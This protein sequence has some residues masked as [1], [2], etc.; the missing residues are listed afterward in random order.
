MLVLVCAP[1]KFITGQT[2]PVVLPS[3][4]WGVQTSTPLTPSNIEMKA[5]ILASL[6]AAAS[7]TT[8]SRVWL[9]GDGKAQSYSTAGY[10]PDNSTRRTTLDTAAKCLDG[11]PA[12]YYV[13]QGTNT[14]K[15]FM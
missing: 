4:F 14:S 12:A 15:F 1:A 9:S 11:T 10:R 5:S 7:A 8:L 6:A 2:G 3:A 13:S